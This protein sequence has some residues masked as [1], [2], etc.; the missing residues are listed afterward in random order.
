M[1]DRERQIDEMGEAQ[2]TLEC[3]LA[4]LPEEELRRLYA[5]LPPRAREHVRLTAADYPGP[6]RDW[7]DEPN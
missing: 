5:D 4:R 7:A 6:L 3:I 2:Y 1:D